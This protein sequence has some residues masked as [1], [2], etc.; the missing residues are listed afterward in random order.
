MR[1]GKPYFKEEYEDV[2]VN[3]ELP[4]GIFDPSRWSSVRPNES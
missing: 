3:E 4:A 2:R 1:D